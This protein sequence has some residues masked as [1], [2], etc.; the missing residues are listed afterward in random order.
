M[1]R[2]W[3]A[4]DNVRQAENSSSKSA[5]GS[6]STTNLASTS[7]DPPNDV[8][9]LL[10]QKSHQLESRNKTTPPEVKDSQSKSHSTLNCEDNS[11]G[12]LSALKKK[13]VIIKFLILI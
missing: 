8:C 12:R 11:T 7:F 4:H 9:S 2:L 1:E 6:A 13:K 5:G 10:Q 3:Q